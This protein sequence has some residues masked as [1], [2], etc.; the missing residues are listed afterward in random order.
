MGLLTWMWSAREVCDEGC[1][2]R[3][4]GAGYGDGG[5][6]VVVWVDGVRGYGMV[7]NERYDS[8]A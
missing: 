6:V 3:M 1:G 5:A 2:K 7:R 4:Y 8:G